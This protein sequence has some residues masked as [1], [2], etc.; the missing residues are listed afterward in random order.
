[1]ELNFNNLSRE[2]WLRSISDFANLKLCNRS[3]V[4]LNIKLKTSLSELEPFHYVLLA[5]LIH[6]LKENNCKGNLDAGS[7]EA[8]EYLNKTLHLYEFFQK[9]IHYIKAE[10]KNIFNLWKIIDSEKE[11]YS[12]QIH[13]YLKNSFFKNKDLSSIKISLIETFYNIFDHAEANGNAYSFIKY[14][15]STQ[16][17]HVA[18]CDFG[19]GIAKSIQTKYNV[20]SDKEAIEIAIKVGT[21]I[22]S[23]LHNKG[24]GLDNIISA[25]THEDNLRIISN[26][27]FLYV[28]GKTRKTFDLDFCFNG[29]LIYFEL[30]IS[31]FEDFELNELFSLSDF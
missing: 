23:K 1:M 20:K 5:C 9:N 4:N 2:E 8:F 6:S 25:L 24:F 28:T 30:S 3:D 15:E 14:E 22:G 11:S 17:L 31:A 12:Q 19:V 13:D 16:K 27:G 18:I 10:D 7:P 21:T 26:S 29:T